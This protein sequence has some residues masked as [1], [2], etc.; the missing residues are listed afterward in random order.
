MKKILLTSLGITLVASSVFANEGAAPVVTK[1]YKR[2]SVKEQEYKQAY[3]NS[4]SNYYGK[5]AIGFGHAQNM[6]VV[7]PS[8]TTQFKSKGRGVFGIA[9]IGYAFPRNIRSDLEFYFDNGIKSRRAGAQHKLQSYIGFL[10]VSYD[11]K[12][13][14]RLVPFINAGAGYGRNASTFNDGS[15][16][17]SSTKSGFAYQA[18]A[19]IS[20]ELRSKIFS[21]FSY[22]YL[23]KGAKKSDLKASNGT[24]MYKTKS[25][26]GQMHTLL[27]GLRM[28]F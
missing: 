18:G 28:H 27:A 10:N 11:F 2:S 22:R 26:S 24:T 3:S 12:A 7:N 16:R 23:N 14:S 20:Y 8:S 9:G 5:L 17:Y 25:T 1:E 15:N 4:Q 21:E 6:K 19:G 13:E